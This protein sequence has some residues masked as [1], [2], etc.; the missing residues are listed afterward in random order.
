MV[1]PRTVGVVTVIGELPDLDLS[2]VDVAMAV[3]LPA[4]VGVKTPA[5]VIVPPVAVQVTVEL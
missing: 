3:A 5:E 1:T 4:L 2:C